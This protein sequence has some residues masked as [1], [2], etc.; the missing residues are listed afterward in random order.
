M[1]VFT[2]N[3]LLS[4]TY[5]FQSTYAYAINNPVRYTDFLGMGPDDKVKDEEEKKKQEEKKEK[6][7]KEEKKKEEE[8]KD[9]PTKDEKKENVWEK[10][11]M[12]KEEWDKLSPTHKEWIIGANEFSETLNEAGSSEAQIKNNQNKVDWWTGYSEGAMDVA[13]Q[14]LTDSDI[15]RG[16][17]SF[18]YTVVSVMTKDSVKKYQRKVDSLSTIKDSLINQMNNLL[19]NK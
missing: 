1:P 14:S 11:D 8:K 2:T 7:T 19:K 17:R 5:S 3:D 9:E 4:E 6:Q 18:G 10:Y 16:G 15:G 13:Q 12:T